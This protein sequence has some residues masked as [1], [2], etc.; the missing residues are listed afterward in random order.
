MPSKNKL[1]RKL[2]GNYFCGIGIP[3]RLTKKFLP[4][5]STCSDTR[6]NKKIKLQYMWC[7]V[8][9]CYVYEVGSFLKITSLILSWI[10]KFD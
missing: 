4:K 7:K 9:L 5:P 3:G 2:C 6:E 10:W 1:V 8:F